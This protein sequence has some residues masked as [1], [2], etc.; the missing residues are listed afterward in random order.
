VLRD[1]QGHR[2]VR[3]EQA[4]EVDGEPGRPAFA[5]RL[6]LADRAGREDQL[7]ILPQADR[8]LRRPHRGSEA[9]ALGAVAAG[10]PHAAHGLEEIERAARA[11][12]QV[13]DLGQR[14]PSGARRRRARRGPARRP[15]ARSVRLGSAAA[16]RIGR[17]PALGRHRMTSPR[18]TVRSTV[19]VNELMDTYFEKKRSSTAPSRNAPEPSKA[20]SSQVTEISR[21]RPKVVGPGTGSARVIPVDATPRTPSICLRVVESPASAYRSRSSRRAAAFSPA[22]PSA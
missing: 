17:S 18:W 11:R 12:E 15:G 4:E 9:G 10:R 22:P 5:A 8:L 21:P 14:S 1:V 19:S 20:A 13:D 16:Q 7:G 2:A 6:Q 3:T